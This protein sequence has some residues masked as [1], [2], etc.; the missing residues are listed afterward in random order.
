MSWGYDLLNDLNRSKLWYWAARFALQRSSVLIGD[1]NPV[2]HKAVD[3]G[4][5]GERIV[6]FPWGI[7]LEA[8]KPGKYP[9]K[10]EHFTLISTRS[11]EPIYGVDVLA[12][13]F[14]TAAQQTPQLRLI[15]LGN[16][17]QGGYLRKVFKTA[18]V[19][20]RVIMPGQVRQADL[21]RYYS[22]ADLYVSA[23]HIDGSSV[24]LMEAM[25]SGRPVLVSDI[26]GNREWVEPEVNG[27]W[28]TDGDED[29][30]AQSISS[31]VDQSEQL[32]EMAEAGRRVAEKKADW[33]KNFP[34][35]FKAYELAL[36]DT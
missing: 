36:G 7:N 6:T 3:L 11:W 35:L 31:A 15:M 16:G 33:N 1:C 18:G 32:A 17:S 25:A 20:E 27:W 2:R 30:L 10:S 29:D 22:M 4:M 28:F 9:P 13:A 5:A 34:Q 12:R 21:P 24:S 19:L 14:V 26:P 23:S 8:F